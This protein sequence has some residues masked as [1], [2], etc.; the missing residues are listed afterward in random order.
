[1]AVAALSM[2][3]FAQPWFL[4]KVNP[5]LEEDAAASA[6]YHAKCS[7]HIHCLLKQVVPS[8]SLFSTNAALDLDRMTDIWNLI[9]ASN[10]LRAV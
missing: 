1:M 4:E 5:I 9:R 2:P 3:A 7:S 10:E 6:T 8:A